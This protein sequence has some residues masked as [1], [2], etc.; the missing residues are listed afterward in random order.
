MQQLITIELGRKSRKHLCQFVVAVFFVLNVL[1][2]TNVVRSRLREIRVP[3]FPLVI[4][5]NAGHNLLVT[6]DR[7]HWKRSV[8]QFLAGI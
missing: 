6:V 5:P 8:D 7:E 2:Y 1:S 4:F 3:T